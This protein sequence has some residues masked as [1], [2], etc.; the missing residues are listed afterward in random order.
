MEYC[1]WYIPT[2]LH[3][4]YSELKKKWFVDMEVFACDFTDEIIEGFKLGSPYS[5]VTNSP[6]K[7]PIESPRD[8]NR[9]LRTMT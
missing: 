5:E 6:S 9:D 7:L 3:T 4:K 8:S 1:H 2:E